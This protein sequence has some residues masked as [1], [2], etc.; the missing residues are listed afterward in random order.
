MGD[1]MMVYDNLECCWSPQFVVLNQRQLC[2]YSSPFG[3]HPFLTLDMEEIQ[4]IHVASKANRD[5]KALCRSW[6]VFPPR[7]KAKNSLLLIKMNDSSN[8]W[9][10]LGC[11]KMAHKWH[12]VTLKHL[13]VADTL[14]LTIPNNIR[15]SPDQVKTNTLVGRG[16]TAVVYDALWN[17][18]TRVAVKKLFD[19]MDNKEVKMFFDEMAM[20]HSLRHPNIVLL[21]GG[22]IDE[23]EN[24]PSI[25][26]EYL[27]R[28]SL[29]SVLYDPLL[30]ITS[31]IKLEILRGVTRALQY[32]HS[33]DP[34]IVHRDLKPGNILVSEKWVAKLADFGLAR[35]C[36]GHDLTEGQGTVKWMAPEVLLKRSYG[37]MADIYSLGLVMWEIIEQNKIYNEFKFNSQVEEQVVH[38]NVRPPMRAD[39][40]PKMYDIITRCWDADPDKRPMAKE[41][42]EILNALG[43]ED[44]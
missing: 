30:D 21:H 34:P 9:F 28:G 36:D 5:K 22:Y 39:F 14:A 7:F 41:I 6:P 24:R 44:L 37:I 10:G 18:T 19:I 12:G 23:E 11:L 38:H 40:P 20:L 3:T 43:P 15:I 13:K 32:L 26:C 4:S 35:K 27:E 33:F 25:V 17:G 31:E 1:T 42:V 29:D 8:Y 2:V 16:G